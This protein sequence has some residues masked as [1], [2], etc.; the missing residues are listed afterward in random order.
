MVI[1]AT[2]RTNSTPRALLLSSEFPPGP[3]GIGQHAFQLARHLTRLGWELHVLSPQPYAADADREAFNRR[4]PFAVT[5]LQDRASGA[6]W[7]PSRL[8]MIHGVMR[9]QRP[10]L[11]IATGYRALLTT[12]AFAAVCRLP[13]VAVGHG[14]EFL[15][16]SSLNR[17]LT[18]RALESATA[19]IAV[20]DYTAGLIRAASRP[21]RLVVIPN[22]ADGERFRTGLDTSALRE[23]WGVGDGP[24][25]LTVG[26]VSERKAQDVVIRALPRI[27]ARHPDATYVMAGLPTLQAAYESLAGEL[28]VAGRVRFAGLVA[29]DDLPVAYNLADVFVLVSRR[30]AAGD[31]EGYGI[32]VQ[33]AA[34][35]GAPAVVS[36]DC[37]LT[38]AIREGETGLSV[39]P[40]DPEATAAAVLALLDDGDRRRKMGRRACEWAKAATWSERIGQYDQVLRGALPPR[41]EPAG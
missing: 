33:E 17:R 31:V 15:G 23:R 4:Q 10:M 24:V 12:A 25:I 36:R 34:L 39:P 38:E 5:P 22:A 27:L 11:L 2:T 9:A 19:V 21:R 1:E 3:G 41:R 37:G 18:R 20:S 28:G 26:H 29:D 13:W 14:T 7:F 40:D 30:T 32:V 6:A 16:R 35:C 8:R